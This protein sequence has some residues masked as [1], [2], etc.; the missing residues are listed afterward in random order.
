MGDSGKVINVNIAFVHMDA[1]D[2]LK[3]YATDKVRGVVQKFA[4]HDT[5][6]HV[7]LKVEKNRQMAEVTMHVDGADFIVKEQSENLYASIDMMVDTLTHQL[8]KNKEKLTAHH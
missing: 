4:H 6:A 2:A 8:R 1:T 5:E 7:I 3:S